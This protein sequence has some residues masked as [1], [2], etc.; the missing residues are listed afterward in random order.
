MIPL[1]FFGVGLQRF[2]AGRWTPLT[3]DPARPVDHV[4]A[5]YEDEADMEDLEGR[6]VD[7]PLIAPE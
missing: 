5:L 2:D 7:W 1:V 3:A 4:R 6:I